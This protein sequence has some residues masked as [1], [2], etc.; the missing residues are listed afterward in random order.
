MPEAAGAA[1][2][3]RVSRP[4]STAWE[5]KLALPQTMAER[6]RGP[7]LRHFVPVCPPFAPCFAAVPR[8]SLAGEAG[9]LTRGGARPGCGALRELQVI[10]SELGRVGAA[11]QDVHSDSNP[12]G[13]AAARHHVHCAPRRP[14]RADGS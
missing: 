2:A 11:A 7:S 9:A 12:W 1:C 4:A 3:R 6:M 8:L 14:G 5:R 10:V 13:T